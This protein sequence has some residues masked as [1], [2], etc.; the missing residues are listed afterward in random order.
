MLIPR[1]RLETSNAGRRSSGPRRW[2]IPG[3]SWT[4]TCSNSLAVTLLT[5]L[6]A[7]CRPSWLS[8]EG[9]RWGSLCDSFSW[10]EPIFWA[11][12]LISDRMLTTSRERSLLWAI[13]DL[14]RHS[15]SFNCWLTSSAVSMEVTPSRENHI[16]RA[17]GRYV[18]CIS[19]W[20]PD[21]VGFPIY[22]N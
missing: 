16:K 20:S 9:A 14:I 6:F 7:L 5:M 4:L 21:L 2:L 11:I 22:I 10:L 15:S 8:E 12:L 18:S 1:L 13:A 3:S 19:S 17:L